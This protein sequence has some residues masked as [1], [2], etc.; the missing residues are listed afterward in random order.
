MSSENKK[1]LNQI[2]ELKE[3]GKYDEWVSKGCY[4]GCIS[5]PPKPCVYIYTD[6]YNKNIGVNQ[7]SKTY[8]T[9]HICFPVFN[10]IGKGT[11]NDLPDYLMENVPIKTLV[12]QGKFIITNK[13]E[14]LVTC[15]LAT[16]VGFGMIIGNKKFMAHIDANTHI[17]PIIRAIDDS[18][19]E[20]EINN[21]E[22]AHINIWEGILD[23]HRHAYKK[24]SKILEKLNIPQTSIIEE[25]VCFMKEVIL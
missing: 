9:E 16:C 13:K 5:Q 14:T 10:F 20:Q 19:K 21:N 25:K 1:Y 4:F 11:M 15:G 24:V 6:I 12:E 22:I 3:I 18:I 23:P 7:V 2:D 17:E 8:K